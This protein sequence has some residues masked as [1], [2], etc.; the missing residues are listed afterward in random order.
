MWK[1]KFFKNNFL[2]VEQKDKYRYY[3]LTNNKDKRGKSFY[4]LSAKIVSV[5]GNGNYI[6]EILCNYRDYNLFKGNRFNDSKLSKKCYDAKFK[7][8][9]FLNSIENTSYKNLI[10]NEKENKISD[11][12]YEGDDNINNNKNILSSKYN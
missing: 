8:I 11:S 9:I 3:F 5:L 10:D 6:I 2:I 7:N 12:G 1:W 4:K